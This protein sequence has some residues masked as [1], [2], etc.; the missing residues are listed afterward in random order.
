MQ[1]DGKVPHAVV[2]GVLSPVLVGA[3]IGVVGALW[4]SDD[5]MRRVVGGLMLLM[6]PVIVARPKRWLADA[7]AD[8]AFDPKLGPRGWMVWTSVGLYAGFIQAGVGV[9]LL[10]A[11]VRMA[12]QDLVRGNGAKVATVAVLTVPALGVF[13][14]GGLVVWAPG[15]VLAAGASVGA[16]MGAKMTVSWGPQFVRWVLVLVVLSSGFHLLLW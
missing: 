2:K 15:L 6:V 7:E 16:W 8:T 10:A 3:A 4:I 12:G 1:R 9:F 11:M 5:W 14:A 13:I